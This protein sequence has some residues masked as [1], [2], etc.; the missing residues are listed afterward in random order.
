MDLQQLARQD[1]L[2][3]DRT[4]NLFPLSNKLLLLLKNTAIASLT[5]CHNL[6]SMSS[7]LHGLKHGNKGGKNRQAQV[8]GQNDRALHRVGLTRNSPVSALRER[9]QVG[10]RERHQRPEQLITM[11]RWY[12]RHLIREKL[13]QSEPPHC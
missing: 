1:V 11:T 2:T 7:H 8:K 12:Q 10:P 3:L 6:E 5:K 4:V 9:T 13:Q